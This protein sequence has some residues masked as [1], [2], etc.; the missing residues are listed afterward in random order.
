M[1]SH[2]NSS[3]YTLEVSVNLIT[4]EVHSKIV[5]KIFI[6]MYDCVYHTLK[7]FK[8]NAYSKNKEANNFNNFYPMSMK[9]KKN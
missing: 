6:G 7:I 8:I 4:L 3:L 1:E 2:F 5:L 9:L